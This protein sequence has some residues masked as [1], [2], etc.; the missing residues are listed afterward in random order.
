MKEFIEEELSSKSYDKVLLLCIVGGFAGIH[1]FY[2]GNKNR[3]ILYSLTAGLMLFGWWND[4]F[5]I[6]VGRM[7]DGEGKRLMNK[8]QLRFYNSKNTIYKESSKENK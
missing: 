8:N 2:L 4:I 5:L 6:S 7:Y 3:G 1:H